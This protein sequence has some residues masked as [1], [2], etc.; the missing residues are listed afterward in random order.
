MPYA[1]ITGATQGIGKAVAAK[2]LQ[3]GF[4]IAICARSKDDLDS[5]HGEWSAQFPSAHI[6]ALPADLGQKEEVIAF[7]DEVLA[8]FPQVDA[9]VNNA[10]LFF[11]GSIA[12][13]PDGQL[14]SLIAVNLYS[15]YYLTRSLLPIMKKRRTGHIFNLCSVASLTAYDNGGAYSIT[16]YALLGFSDNLRQELI[17][18]RIK[19][20]AVMPGAT[21]SR[22]WS[23][24]GLPQ[25][26]LMTAEDVAAVIW[27]AFSLSPQANVEHITMRPLQGDI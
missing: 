15:A 8:K 27:T 26:R 17:P 6:L 19:V 21:W 2:F 9:L 14:E 7:A 24:S 13:E 22:S 25:E 16:K 18:D 4:S 5:L 12:D 1:V 20:T 3:E 11:P 23:S 10:G